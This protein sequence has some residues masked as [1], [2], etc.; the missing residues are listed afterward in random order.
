[1]SPPPINPTTHKRDDFGKLWY[2]PIV[3]EL[4]PVDDDALEVLSKI[5][6]VRLGWFT[7]QEALTYLD[8]FHR[9]LAPYCPAFTGEVE[10][11][12]SR[13]ARI[14]QEP[15]LCTTI[16][17]T[18]SRFFTLPGAGGLARCYLI[19]HRLWQQ[20]ERLIQL[21]IYGQEKHLRRNRTLGT[22]QSFLLLSEWHPQSLRSLFT[23]SQ[24]DMWEGRDPRFPN[25]ASSESREQSYPAR[26]EKDLPDRANQSD[27]LLWIM[28]GTALNLAH[29]AGVFVDACNPDQAE[30]SEW[31]GPLRIRK[32]LYVYVTNLSVRLGFQNTFTQ[33]IILTR[34]ILPAEGFGRRG[35]ENGDLSMDLWLGLVRL[36]RTASA[37]FFRT[38]SS[39]KAHLRN[40]DYI[41]FLQSF[42]VTLLKWYDDFV[43]SQSVLKEDI[44]RLLSIEYHNLKIYTHALAIEAVLER[45]RF[46]NFAI[47]LRK[48]RLE[49]LSTCYLP[50]DFEFIQVITNGNII[51]QTTISMAD[52]GRL[53]FIPIRQLQCIMSA[54]FFRFKAINICTRREDVETSL[55]VLERC[56]K[57]LGEAD[58]DEMDISRD[59]KAFL[60]SHVQRICDDVNVFF[61]ALIDSDQDLGALVMA[62]LGEPP[63]VDATT[64]SQPFLLE[65]NWNQEGFAVLGLPTDLTTP[66]SS[67]DTFSRLAAV[68]PPW[69]LTASPWDTSV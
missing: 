32:L 46:Q 11:G 22:I 41:I 45:T 2:P 57:A 55:V 51:L 24:S 65:L 63:A 62:D 43:A 29:E 17:M 33:D 36:S 23:S 54:F 18:A 61:S 25:K 13:Y 60:H 5:P 20:C 6:Y 48:D 59:T 31:L 50:E 9:H 34:A 53:R 27:R 39:T 37:M 30:G 12:R 21:L 4:S 58:L 16:L 1:M 14:A 69:Q 42:S 38:P 28:V 35:A 8:I 19:H 49:L 47:S 52:N 10:V 66:W 68:D 56:V 67:L 7:A 3:H 44:Q 26:Y 64:A 15:M 40:G